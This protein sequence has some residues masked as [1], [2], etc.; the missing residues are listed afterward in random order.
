MLLYSVKKKT[1]T[2]LTAMGHLGERWKRN[3]AQAPASTYPCGADEVNM[4]W[5]KID[6]TLWMDKNVVGKFH[7][8]QQLTWEFMKEVDSN[9]PPFVCTLTYINELHHT[10]KFSRKHNQPKVLVVRH[11]NG[12]V[13][14]RCPAEVRFL[15]EK[16]KAL[17]DLSN[18]KTEGT[19]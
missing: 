1:S 2:F 19:A 4:P 18:R 9:V 16:E 12:D 10:I 6:F 5:N 15:T 17:V 7:V 8:G 14:T 13:S 3:E 11:P